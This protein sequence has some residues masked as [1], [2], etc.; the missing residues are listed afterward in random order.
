MT[1]QTSQIFLESNLS[2][3]SILL[4][5]ILAFSGSC[6][7]TEV[8][9]A[10]HTQKGSDE[11][12]IGSIKN[13]DR[14]SD[15]SG[16][17][18]GYLT[19]GCT[20]SLSDDGFAVDSSCVL[21][22]QAGK[23]SLKDLASRWTWHYQLGPNV[24]QQP[25]VVTSELPQE[26][27]F[28]VHFRFT[29]LGRETLLDLARQA[30]YALSLQLTGRTQTVEIGETLAKKTA[31]SS[32]PR[33]RFVRINFLSIRSPSQGANEMSIENLELKWEGRWRQGSFA[34]YT[35]M[36]G[37]YETTISAS[38]FSQERSGY[39]YN[40]FKRTEPGRVWDTALNAFERFG[41]YNA[42]G[43][44]QWLMFDFKENPVAIQGIKIDG[45]DSRFSSGDE[46]SPDFF[47]LEGSQNG[48]DWV[49]IEGSRFD[50]VNTTILTPFEWDKTTSP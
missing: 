2:K 32:T 5:I 22:D 39:P 34:N 46:G 44:P 42:I 8:S 20:V 18:P 49:L 1:P 10:I 31:F 12:A 6:K 9:P 25:V 43:G 45:G 3:F 47:Y 29:G 35:G 19:L 40:V 11:A 33:Y 24:S 50:N 41:D 13:T 7:R 15:S 21:A 38:S 4:S 26:N 28:H 17:V 36:L 16:G 48:T 14:P 23:A 37:P 30:K 27:P